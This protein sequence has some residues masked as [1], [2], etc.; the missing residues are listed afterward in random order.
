MQFLEVDGAGDFGENRERVRIPLEQVLVAL[1]AGAFLDEDL[2][3]VN[4][5]VAFFFA[6][7]VVDDGQ[8]TVAIHGD[9]LALRIPNGVDTEEANESIGLGV[10]LGLLARTGSGATDVERTH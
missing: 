9:Q 1:Y 8:D 7:L 6:V 2:R 3:A 10:L 4:D 5:L